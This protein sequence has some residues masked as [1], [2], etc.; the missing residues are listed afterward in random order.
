MSRL[1]SIRARKRWPRGVGCEQKQ[2]E[3]LVEKKKSNFSEQQT[4]L[5]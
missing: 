4:P 5:P 1:A 3:G 2:M